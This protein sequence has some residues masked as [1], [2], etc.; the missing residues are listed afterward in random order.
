M[1]NLNKNL[2]VAFKNPLKFLDYAIAYFNY[3]RA[4]AVLTDTPIKEVGKLY[5]EIFSSHFIAEIIEKSKSRPGF[6]YL[7]MLTPFRAPTIYVLCRIFKPEVLVETGVAQGFSSA[8]ILNAL[9][10][11]NKGHLYS[12]DLPNQPGQEIGNKTGW[13][14]PD[15]FRKRWELILGP[16]REKL[17]AL[18]RKLNKIDFFYHDSDH[19]YENMVFEFDCAWQYLK[20]EG[21]LLADDITD[22]LAFDQ[23]VRNENCKFRKLFKLGIAFKK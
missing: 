5:N 6:S 14:I 2:F 19:S 23:L 4:V 10:L 15:S 16:S 18:L 17:P 13:L 21:L 9:E 1:N 3:K 22:S 7:T 8:F 11:N 20:K 12:I